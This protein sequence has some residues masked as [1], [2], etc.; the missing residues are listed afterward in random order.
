[1]GG[2]EKVGDRGP[3]CLICDLPNVEN[4]KPRK[5]DLGFKNLDPFLCLILWDPISWL[6]RG[7][8]LKLPIPCMRK[9]D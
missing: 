4:I 3:L 2:V 1:M 6:R 5:T 8:F 9:P 7:S